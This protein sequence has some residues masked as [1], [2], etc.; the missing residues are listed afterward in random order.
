MTEIFEVI[1]SALQ[2]ENP[3]VRQAAIESAGEL[4]I[5]LLDELSKQCGNRDGHTKA[6]AGMAIDD[7][8]RKLR[9]INA[10]W[11]ALTK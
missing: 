2:H 4:T 3:A 8:W 1:K 11:D 9:E 6:L 10:N 7:A 5:G